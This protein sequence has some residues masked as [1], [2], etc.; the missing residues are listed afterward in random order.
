MGPGGCS[1]ESEAVYRCDRPYAVL[2]GG[3]M[4]ALPPRILFRFGI[5]RRVSGGERG[6]TNLPVCLGGVHLNCNPILDA[7]KMFPTFQ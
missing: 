7:P 2:L 3:G 6:K 1:L 5:D 4:E